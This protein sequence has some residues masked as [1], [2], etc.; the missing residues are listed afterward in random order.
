MCIELVAPSLSVWFEHWLDEKW[1]LP[2]G[3]RGELSPEMIE[4]DDL[5]DPDVVWRGFY[6]FGLAKRLRADDGR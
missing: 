3:D 4:T 5:P 2:P 6:R 1:R